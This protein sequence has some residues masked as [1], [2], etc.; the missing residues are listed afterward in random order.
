MFTI[1]FDMREFEAALTD[2]ERNQMPFALSQALNDTA[3]DVMRAWQQ[4]IDTKIDRPT[5]FTRRG[6]FVQRSS[7]QRLEAVVGIKDVQAEYLKWQV[8]GGTQ[9]SRRRAI[10]VAVKQKRNKYGNA[11]RGSLRRVLAKPNTF[12]GRVKG[13]AGVWQRMKNKR[14]PLKLLFAYNASHQYQR[15]LNLERPARRVASRVVQGHLAR[16]LSVAIATAR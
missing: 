6:V 8:R 7:K 1:D 11:P 14:R 2:F 15:K 16:R 13:R 12:S 3:Q 4:E 9:S 5:P 10:P